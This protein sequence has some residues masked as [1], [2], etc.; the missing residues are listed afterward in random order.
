MRPFV[1]LALL[2]CGSDPTTVKGQSHD[3]DW[4]TWG[5]GIESFG[6]VTPG[7]TD[8]GSNNTGFS[9]YDGGYF[10]TYTFTISASGNSCTF[11]NVGLIINISNGEVDGSGQVGTSTC[12]LGAGDVEYNAKLFFDGTVSQ[13]TTVAGA[14]GED[15]IFFF[16]GVWSGFVVDTGATKQISGTIGSQNVEST[17]PGGLVSI[18]GSF[19]A[20]Q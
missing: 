10:G 7:P 16:D 18:S 1:F 4:E 17:N 8:T 3:H 11:S 19:M 9:D 6:A 12:N 20:E 15:N 2:A 13:D 14:V 5:S